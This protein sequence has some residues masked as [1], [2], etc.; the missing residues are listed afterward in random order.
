MNAIDGATERAIF[1]FLR[2]PR[3]RYVAERASQL[4][5]V[6]LSTLYEWRRN[7]VYVPDFTLA[8]PAAWSYRDLVFVRLLAWLRQG[9]MQRPLASQLVGKVRSMA[10]RGEKIRSLRADR[11]TLLINEERTSRFAGQPNMLPFDN[12]FALLSTFDM[13]EPID[14]LRARGH[15]RIWAPHLVT[16]SRCTRISPYVLAGD[17][18][19]EKTR[20]PTSSIYALRE[21]RGLSSSDIVR[22][23][24]GLELDAADD[25]YLLE[26]RLRGIDLPEPT[27]A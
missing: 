14:E 7:D 1:Y 8:S 10:G 18:C 20:I 26:R 23:Y 2:H 13:L 21:D 25:A 15:H 12:I 16:P 22:L 11:Y 24:P 27:F 19:V 17:P 9:G 5:G 3:G 6:P 4:S